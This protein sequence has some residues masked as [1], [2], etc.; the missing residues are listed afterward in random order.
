MTAGL[1]VALALAGAAAQDQKPIPAFP[2]RAE[3]VTLDVVVVDKQGRPVRGLT[4]ADFTVLEDGR[5]Q[6]VV[7]FDALES[8]PIP[9]E[10]AETTRG[11]SPRTSSR[12]SATAA[13]GWARTACSSC[14]RRTM[15]RTRRV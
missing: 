11:S 10:S 9:A 1:L 7:G 6:V 14:S 13:T 5:P 4:A 2:A 8:A 15:R 12:C 3:A